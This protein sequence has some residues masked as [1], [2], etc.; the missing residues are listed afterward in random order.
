MRGSGRSSP[1]MRRAAALSNFFGQ[2]KVKKE[3]QPRVT[4]VYAQRASP[5]EMYMR[6]RMGYKR[7]GFDVEPPQSGLDYRKRI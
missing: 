7:F 6:Q 3:V 5:N 1:A 4:V 2:Q